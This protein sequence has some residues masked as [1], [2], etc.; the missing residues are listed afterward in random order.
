MKEGHVSDSGGRPWDTEVH[1]VFELANGHAVNVVA[2]VVAGVEDGPTLGVIGGMHGDETVSLE[3]VR[4]VV[5]GTDR[6]ELKGTIVAVPVANA[7]AFQRLSRNTPLDMENLNR[8]LPGSPDGLLSE[9]LAWTLCSKVIDRCDYLVDLHSGGTLAT[10][11]YVISQTG[12]EDMAK[13][14]GCT[15]VSNVPL[16]RGSLSE[17]AMERGIPSIVGELGGGQYR[18]AY[19]VERGVQGIWNVMSM[20]GMISSEIHL[21]ADQFR[22][23]DLLTIRPRN[24]GLLYSELEADALGETFEKGRLLGQVRSPYTFEVLE[25]MRGPFDESVLILGRESFTKVDPGDYGFM[26][27]D[28]ATMERI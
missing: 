17:Y 2:H 23:N 24:G 13:T 15:F 11:D 4:Q 22:V 18:N 6:G 20:L 16:P 19:Y 8:I 25:E 21:P 27:A 7:Y 26:V 9:Q 12:H 28:K 5:T 3:I 14:F 1:N 10:V